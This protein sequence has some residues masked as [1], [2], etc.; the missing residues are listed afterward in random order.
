MKVFEAKEKEK[1]TGDLVDS[2]QSASSSISSATTSK[3]Q[4]VAS[5]NQSQEQGHPATSAP[6]IQ[7]DLQNDSKQ[8]DR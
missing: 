4:C 1:V 5:A 8:Q 2:S 6:S 7:H 3:N